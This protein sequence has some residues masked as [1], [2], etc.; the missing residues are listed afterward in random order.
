MKRRAAAARRPSRPSRCAD[1]ARGSA[2]STRRWSSPCAPRAP[3]PAALLC[4]LAGHSAAPGALPREPVRLLTDWV[5]ETE[6]AAHG[7]RHEVQR[8][9][10]LVAHGGRPTADE[11]LRFERAR[12]IARH[13]DPSAWTPR[14][15]R[16]RGAA[17]SSSTGRAARLAPL[18]CGALCGAAGDLLAALARAAS[19]SPAMP[20]RQPLVE[21]A[22]ADCMA[23]AACS[24]PPGV[25]D[26]ARAWRA[27][28][29]AP[30]C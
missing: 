20:A 27:D 4:H 12:S 19:S 28:R 26:L 22:R 10:D 1:D 25:L 11:R 16:A 30:T 18:S 29:A 6:P 2:G 21:A 5:P 7:M 8:Q 9:L 14:R 13:D 17:T 15:D 24:V 3:L 23:R